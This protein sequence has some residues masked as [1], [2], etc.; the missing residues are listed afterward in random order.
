LIE[1]GNTP[2]GEVVTLHPLLYKTFNHIKFTFHHNLA[3]IGS[4]KN[5]NMVKNE[6]K[7]DE[8]AYL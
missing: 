7:G 5:Q 4:N 2:K 6:D 8:A 3:I 1:T